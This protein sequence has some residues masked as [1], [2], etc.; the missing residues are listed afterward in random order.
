M[1]SKKNLII[2]STLIIVGA[3]IYIVEAIIG[4]QLINR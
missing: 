2:V 1:P 4:A 3:I